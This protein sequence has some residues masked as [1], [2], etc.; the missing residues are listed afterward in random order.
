[1]QAPGGG[2]VGFALDQSADV[3]YTFYGLAAL[4]LCQREKP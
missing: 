1:M 3:E 4:A 2:F